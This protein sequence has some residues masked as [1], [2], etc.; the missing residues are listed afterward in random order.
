M[1]RIDET[2]GAIKDNVRNFKKEQELETY[3]DLTRS[4]A[5][6]QDYK[7]FWEKNVPLGDDLAN[8]VHPAEEAIGGRIGIGTPVIH[9]DDITRYPT[10]ERDMNH[11]LNAHS[12]NYDY[13]KKIEKIKQGGFDASVSTDHIGTIGINAKTKLKG[14]FSRDVNSEFNDT[15]RF[16]PAEELINLVPNDASHIREELGK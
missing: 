4:Y 12:T 1:N 6:E 5:K 14:S 9:A 10:I 11:G 8:K 3:G 13:D 16:V 7:D 15:G 2:T